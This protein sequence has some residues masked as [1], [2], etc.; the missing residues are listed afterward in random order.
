MQQRLL[1]WAI[2]VLEDT[3]ILPPGLLNLA[4]PTPVFA[5]NECVEVFLDPL[6]L[7]DLL[8]LWDRLRT[9]PQPSVT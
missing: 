1:G 6:P 2:R 9:G 8:S 4:S 7:A 3:P 5:P